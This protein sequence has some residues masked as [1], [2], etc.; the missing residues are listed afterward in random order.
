MKTLIYS[1]KEFEKPYLV[2]ANKGRHEITITNK[3]LTIETA[4]LAAGFEGIAVFTN[5]DASADVLRKLKQ[6]GVSYITTRSV[7][8]DHID[9]EEA[10]ALGI[11][12]GNVPHYSPYSVAE[13]TVAM[14]LTLNRRLILANE[15]AQKYQFDLSSLIGFDMH[16]KT[17]GIIGF[18]EIGSIVGKILNGFGC[19]ILVYD[20]LMERCLTKEFD[21][22]YVDVDLLL[23]ESDII[24]LHMPL[25][26]DTKYFINEETISKMKKGV[27]LIN[28]S[29]G[30]IVNTIDVL[31]AVRD[32]KI[33]YLGLD[34]YEHER[35]IFFRNHFESFGRDKTLVNLM[36]FKN[37][38]I[39]GHQ[40]FLTKEA[41]T[42]IAEKTIENLT[43]W[44]KR[45]ENSF[46]STIRRISRENEL[47]SN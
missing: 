32:G 14:M 33:G 40:A 8:T 22:E 41:L 4:C 10:E 28:T 34:V 15:K 39:T 9:L 18:G 23:E 44:E 31:D 21:F 47:M 38:L 17:V 45:D 35:G 3:P 29:R 42:N 11:G 1:V 7:G 20:K 46:A 43:N 6:L 5:D 36:N 27:M 19:R 16:G 30:G 13:H 25:T 26:E 12:V 24:S 37:V 2:C